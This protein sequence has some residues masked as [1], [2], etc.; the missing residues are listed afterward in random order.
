[1]LKYFLLIIIF[2]VKAFGQKTYADFIQQDAGIQWAAEYNQILNLSPKLATYSVR[3]LAF[4]KATE[5]GCIESFNLVNEQFQK[6]I[7]CL[8]DTVGKKDIFTS[9][10]NPYRYFIRE[11]SYAS[12]IFFKQQSGISF[13]EN[14]FKSKF[15]ID[16]VKQLFYYKNSALFVTNSLVS[17]LYLE[18]VNDSFSNNPIFSWKKYYSVCTNADTA[19]KLTITEKQKLVDLG[20]VSEF[21]NFKYDPVNENINLKVFTKSNPGISH[22]L[23]EDI[24]KG[25]ITAVDDK[26][27]IIPASKIFTVNNPAMRIETFDENGK[28]KG[29]KYIRNEVNVDGFY[30]FSISQH[31]YFDTLKNILISEVNYLDFQQM[32]FSNTGKELGLA[33]FF[34]VYF[35]KPSLYKKPNKKGFLNDF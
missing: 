15:Q 7:F 8:S 12:N 16:E 2:P 13:K 26:N 31:Y 14:A 30:N 25:K 27:N 21:Y 4:R 33:F 24:L 35:I 20:N 23:F 34:R 22:Q 11:H 1:M 17:P 28:I 5:N 19:K 29:H 9:F 10:I 3:E 18:S 6:Q 32:L